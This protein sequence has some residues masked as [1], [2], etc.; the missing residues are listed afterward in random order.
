MCPALLAPY[1]T[2][3][4]ERYLKAIR[5]IILS[6]SREYDST[7]I[8]WTTYEG[9]TKTSLLIVR[10][11]TGLLAESAFVNATDFIPE[12]LCVLR[13]DQPVSKHPV[14]LMQPQQGDLPG[15]CGG[16]GVSP[17][18]PLDDSRYIPEIEGVVGLGGGGQQLL[19][20]LI[21]HINGAVHHCMRDCT[22]LQQSAAGPL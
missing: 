22:H 15:V 10:W 11:Q 7:W 19:P 4:S 9:K 17:H 2:H 13:T 21:V 18:H 20:D 12:P 3:C 5:A 16:L 6:A 14:C 1:S 8:L